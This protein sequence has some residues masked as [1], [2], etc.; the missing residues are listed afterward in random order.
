MLHFHDSS[1][2]VLFASHETDAGFDT[3]V[4]SSQAFCASYL[5]PPDSF[6]GDNIKSDDDFDD[7]DDDDASIQI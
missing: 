5:L 4:Y 7:D 3:K 1:S 2:F 6:D